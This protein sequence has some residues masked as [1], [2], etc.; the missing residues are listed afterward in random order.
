MNRKTLITVL[1]L[2]V[3]FTAIF[4]LSKSV[5]VAGVGRVLAQ[6]HFGFLMGA[7]LLGVIPVFISGFRS[8]TLLK[9][10]NIPLSVFNLT[11][12]AQIG[13]FFA[14]LVP[15]IVG[16]DGARFFYLSKLTPGRVRQACST[17]LLDRVLGFASLFILTT[18]CIPL[19]WEVL[20]RQKTTLWVAVSFLSVGAV[21]LTLGAIAMALSQTTLQ[22][23]LRF[24]QQRFKDSPLVQ[25]LAEITS[26]FIGN[27]RSLCVVMAA[28]LFTQTLIC[29]LFWSVGRAVGISLP[30]WSW[31]SFVP[32]MVVSGI[33][34]IT[35]AGIG[36][37]DYLLFL[38]LG[39]A[40]GGAIEKERIAALSLLLLLLTFQGA[41]LG[42]LVYLLFKPASVTVPPLE[43]VTTD[44]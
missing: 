3:V 19:N 40:A 41:T 25:D 1:K 23:L 28:A 8:H 43:T 5:D 44:S 36:V 32:V 27:K 6:T 10:L 2:L 31:M 16:D 37:R 35:F 34:P 17:V 9:V 33:L 30:L 42:G 15:G 24:F 13:Q 14:V 7:L 26:A 4:W 20:A 38:F 39:A 29:A 12:I 21:V 18:I 22:S 11:C